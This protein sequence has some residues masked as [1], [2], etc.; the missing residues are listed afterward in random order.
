M[1]KK[2]KYLQLTLQKQVLEGL[3]DIEQLA[4]VLQKL[5]I[6][7]INLLLQYSFLRQQGFVNLIK[8]FSSNKYVED[9]SLDLSVNSLGPA[10]CSLVCQDL[11]NFVN[12]KTLSLNLGSNTIKQQGAIALGKE[13]SKLKSLKVL[14]LNVSCNS[15][16]S[17]GSRLMLNEMLKNTTLESLDL[18]IQQNY[19]FDIGA[20]QIG[21]EFIVSKLQKLQLDLMLNDLTQE[22]VNQLLSQLNISNSLIYISLNLNQNSIQNYSIKEIFKHL[23]QLK[24]IKFLELS[25]KIEINTDVEQYQQFGRVLQQCQY[26]NAIKIN[27]Y[28]EVNTVILN[29][30]LTFMESKA[31]I[32][33][34][35]QVQDAR[36]DTMARQIKQTQ[37]LP[38]D[39][40]SKMILILDALEK[41]NPDYLQ[42]IS[43]IKEIQT[44]SYR[45]CLQFQVFDKKMKMKKI[46][47]IFENEQNEYFD[48]IVIIAQNSKNLLRTD[49]ILKILD[50]Y[51]L[52]EYELFYVIEY[53]FFD[54]SLSDLFQTSSSSDL[55]F[56][57]NT[58]LNDNLFRM[59]WYAKKA[60]YPISRNEFSKEM[61]ANYA[62]FV[63]QQQQ[64]GQIAVKLNIVH[65]SIFDGSKIYQYESKIEKIYDLKQILIQ[66]NLKISVKKEQFLLEMQ[67]CYSDLFKQNQ[68]ILE[69]IVKNINQ[70]AFLT[71][72]MHNQEQSW[73]SIR[74]FTINEEYNLYLHKFINLEQAQ[75]KFDQFISADNH[76]KRFNIQTYIQFTISSNQQG[77]YIIAQKNLQIF[78]QFLESEFSDNIEQDPQTYQV[79][80]PY[81]QENEE[82]EEKSQKLGGGEKEDSE[83]LR[84]K[85][86]LQIE[87][88]E[89][90]EKVYDLIEQEFSEINKSELYQDKIDDFNII[91]EDKNK[92]PQ[93]NTQEENFYAQEEKSVGKENTTEIQLEQK[94]KQGQI[95]DLFELNSNDLEESEFQKDNMDGSIIIEENIEQQLNTKEANLYDQDEEPIICPKFYEKPQQNEYSYKQYQ[96]PYEIEKCLQLLRVWQLFI[97]NLD[98]FLEQKILPKQLHIKQCVQLEAL[99]IAVD[100]NHL[101][102]INKN[103][104]DALFKERFTEDLIE[105]CNDFQ[106]YSFSDYFNPFFLNPKQ[107]S[108]QIKKVFDTFDNKQING[109]TKLDY[110]PFL[111]ILNQIEKLILIKL[112]LFYTNFQ[113]SENDL[114]LLI[115]SKDIINF[116]D[117]K[118]IIQFFQENLNFSSIQFGKIH[119]GYGGGIKLKKSN[120]FY[121]DEYIQTLLRNKHLSEIEKTKITER[122]HKCFQIF[123]KQ[124]VN[125]NTN[126]FQFNN[127]D[128][129]QCVKQEYQAKKHIFTNLNLIYTHLVIESILKQ[130][131]Q[132]VCINESY[133]QIIN[134]ITR[135]QTSLSSLAF[136]LQFCEEVNIKMKQNSDYFELKNKQN[137][138]KLILVSKK[139]FTQQQISLVY[140]QL[141]QNQNKINSLYLSCVKHTSDYLNPIYQKFKK[142]S[143]LVNIQS[144]TYLNW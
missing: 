68:I 105:I 83:R 101:E 52:D 135:K 141:N 14:N 1:S 2:I 11:K 126:E 16:G 127:K 33:D 32:H 28:V 31:Q 76:L 107:S 44:I 92:E 106:S 41:K 8:I 91:E 30:S 37:Q 72:L 96:E 93:A 48:E 103:Q 27:F 117:L 90:Q 61:I 85:I 95:Q 102:L 4:L 53:E 115:F 112:K 19:L 120:I 144:I 71:L 124:T 51:Y 75:Q 47:E 24:R 82:Q 129:C 69:E 131:I 104:Q 108:V 38:S 58:Q 86:I 80:K 114:N 12:V 56:F 73:Y 125:E 88:K 143:R 9:L 42:S 43:Q 65:P 100:I 10:G 123:N 5:Q 137:L 3:D 39:Y 6:Q 84:E 136:I 66:P 57:Q 13:L 133:I 7:D 140:E 18:N 94:E 89:Q 67:S 59:Y 21:M 36:L 34:M 17:D 119:S 62:Y 97:S 22:G 113:I 99:E 74:V 78:Y 23:S 55:M 64:N 35:F 138:V 70:R 60:L 63:C 15:I 49:L 40:E 116:L 46:I 111:A 54:H 45:C 29:R 109:E 110:Q 26:L 98:V 77:V 132:R 25:F 128:I 134:L 139:E 79:I 50:S 87:Q 122:A 142:L 130:T 81:E 20:K 118:Q 121:Q